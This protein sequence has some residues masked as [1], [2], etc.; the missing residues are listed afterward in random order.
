MNLNASLLAVLVFL[1]LSSAS[2]AQQPAV[3]RWR[4]SIAFSPGSEFDKSMGLKGRK[5]ADG[6]FY[7]Q[8][9]MEW[10]LSSLVDRKTG[11]RTHGI[12][13]TD[14]YDGRGWRAWR[15][16]VTDDA[17]TLPVTVVNRKVGSC[18]RSSGC[19]HYEDVVIS[20]NEEILE[21]RAASGLRIRLTGADGAEKI[22]SLTGEDLSDQL[23]AA[24]FYSDQVK[25]G[26][27]AR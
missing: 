7:G 9:A 3:E 18:N 27:P 5:Y 8:P 23:T 10:T 1:V 2:L 19:S 26:S 17:R 13:F 25:A 21:S 14:A 22:I 4:S 15:D 12:V 20:I 11:A 6:S 16:A 24:R